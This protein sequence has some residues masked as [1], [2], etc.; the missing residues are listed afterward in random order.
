MS[1]ASKRLF[2]T[3]RRT[4]TGESDPFGKQL[5]IAR[6][7]RVIGYPPL[8]DTFDQSKGISCGA[9]T[10]YGCLTFLLADDFPGALQVEAADGSWIPADPVP[11]AFVVNIGDIIDSL[12]SHQYKSTYHRVIHK[13]SKFRVSIP[14]FFEPPRDMTIE[15][16]PSMVPQGGTGIAPFTYFDHLK[17]MIYR[18]F[19]PNDQP[20]PEIPNANELTQRG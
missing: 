12:T 5:L 11:N 16:I 17:S 1:W 8:P 3:L 18:H 7:L 13:G 6:V 4:I 14:F 19:V 20:L 9:H 15:P 2:L 10:D